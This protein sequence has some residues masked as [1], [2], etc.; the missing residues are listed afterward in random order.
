MFGNPGHEADTPRFAGNDKAKARGYHTSATACANGKD[1]AR[2]HLHAEEEP[3]L[4]KETSDQG[5]PETAGGAYASRDSPRAQ[6][7]QPT[8]GMSNAD[9]V[10]EQSA[11]TTT[12]PSEDDYN[13][14]KPPGFAGG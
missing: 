2:E 10:A 4:Q 6:A 1:V 3:Q 11:G 12:S 14:A 9:I 8:E 13:A 7:S 5:A